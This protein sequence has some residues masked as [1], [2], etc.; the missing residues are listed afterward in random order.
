MY[1]KLSNRPVSILRFQIYQGDGIYKSIYLNADEIILSDRVDL[2][3]DA[4]ASRVARWQ[5]NSYR[6]A[7]RRNMI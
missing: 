5:F 1:N 4:R 2:D 6:G 7:W 3:Y